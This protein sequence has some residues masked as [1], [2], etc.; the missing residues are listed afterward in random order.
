MASGGC[1]IECPMGPAG[2]ARFPEDAP[3]TAF[4]SG[5]ARRRRP[6]SPSA[7]GG[8]LGATQM[9]VQRVAASAA[10]Q[11]PDHAKAALRTTL[12]GPAEYARGRARPR[13]PTLLPR[14]AVGAQAR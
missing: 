10:W 2:G 4:Q 11:R 12:V 7:L 9:S 1:P 13:P 8:R 6:P 3:A 14:P 5:W